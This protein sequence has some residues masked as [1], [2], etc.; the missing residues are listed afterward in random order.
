[1]TTPEAID[2]VDHCIDLLGQIE[3]E[4]QIHREFAVNQISEKLWE[5]RNKLSGEDHHVNSEDVSPLGNDYSGLCV[6]ICKNTGMTQQEVMNHVDYISKELERD[7]VDVMN[8]MIRL[9]E[10]LD[11]KLLSASARIR[12]MLEEATQI[13][14]EQGGDTDEA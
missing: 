1:M 12:L 8:E 4:D 10:E 6:T 5:L 14:K 9:S 7:R 3:T 2:L 11:G 13:L